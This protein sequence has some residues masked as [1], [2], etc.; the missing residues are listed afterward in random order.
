MT[1]KTALVLSAGGY[2]GAYQA[3][4]W[5]SLHERFQP[6]L[7]IGASVGALNGWPIAAGCSPAELAQEWLDPSTSHLLKFH[8]RPGLRNRWFEPAPLLAKAR[9]MYATY[10]PTTPFSLVVVELP[11]LRRRLIPASAV[12]PD[13]LLATCS[14][15]FLF[16]SVTIGDRRF[17]DGALIENMPLWAA[18]ELGATRIVAVDALPPVTPWWVQAG[19]RVL[20]RVVPHKDLP[21]ETEVVIITPSE[22]LGTARDAIIWKRDNIARWIDLGRRDADHQFRLQ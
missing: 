9:H 17:T 3:G 5:E 6:D 7:I 19:S 13:H 15:P 11:W 20:R 10:T 2:F 4:V 1:P 22:Y 8:R 16:P 18:A 14:I 21:P 12:T